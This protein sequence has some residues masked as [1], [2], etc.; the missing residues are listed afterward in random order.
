MA[1]D[2]VLADPSDSRS[3]LPTVRIYRWSPSAVSLGVYQ[4]TDA[5]DGERC[6][7]RGWDIVR[8]PTGGRALLHD[9]DMSH[10][11]VLPGGAASPGDLRRLLQGVAAALTDALQAIGVSVSYF[12]SRQS[13]RSRS[14]R[15]NAEGVGRMRAG[16]C[17]DSRVRGELL[18]GGKKV[19]SAAQRVY[20]R[21]IL[22]HGSLPLTGDVGAIAD[23]LQWSPPEREREG[24]RLRALACTVSDAAGREVGFEE[25]AEA[26]VVALARRF[27]MTYRPDVLNDEELA[28]IVRRRPSFD[29]VT[30]T[31]EPLTEAYA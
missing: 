5:V 7:R 24:R 23:V 20:S 14:G 27:Q 4:P 9:G 8:R 15:Q 16:L 1:A 28:E 21:A 18:V 26:T 13:H 6:R 2:A 31:A 22:Q 29:L 11:V 19:A 12:L 3:P 25:L 30:A 17:L 10:S